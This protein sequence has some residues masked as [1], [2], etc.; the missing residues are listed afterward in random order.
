MNI[1]NLIDETIKKNIENAINTALVI[2]NNID[3]LRLDYTA[4]LRE[5]DNWILR[6]QLC[7]KFNYTFPVLKNYNQ[8]TV[9]K[10][11]NIVVYHNEVIPTTSDICHYIKY[12]LYKIIGNSVIYYPNAELL[13]DIKKGSLSTIDIKSFERLSILNIIGEPDPDHQ[14]LNFI[15]N[16]IEEDCN[17]SF[18]GN[19]INHGLYNAP[20]KDLCEYI[21]N[22]ISFNMNS[23]IEI[24][25]SLINIFAP[26]LYK[27]K[28][29]TALIFKDKD[30]YY[31]INQ[32]IANKRLVLET[33][34]KIMFKVQDKFNVRFSYDDIIYFKHIDEIV[35]DI[36]N[37]TKGE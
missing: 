19:F 27:H 28:Y 14:I 33:Y 18:E 35:N 16:S 17:I 29:S 25:K 23:I 6:K 5:C 1:E 12:L 3:A 4:K 30:T 21:H 13:I 34:Y 22:K 8:L 15:I 32:F 36:I 26:I 20:I 9:A 11:Y 7:K 37:K 10:I 31:I 24:R 2:G